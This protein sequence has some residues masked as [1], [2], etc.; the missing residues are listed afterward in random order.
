MQVE[1]AF[2]EIRLE[3]IQ[4]ICQLA[5]KGGTSQLKRLSP[6]ERKMLLLMV[7]AMGKGKESIETETHIDLETLKQRL[8]SPER[9]ESSTLRQKI[10]KGFQKLTGGTVSS[11][12]LSKEIAKVNP[13]RMSADQVRREQ[14]RFHEDIKSKTEEKYDKQRERLSPVI[15]MQKYY[16][17]L[18]ECRNKEQQDRE[19]KRIL[20][21]TSLP[22]KT[23]TN[24]LHLER[25][26]HYKQL[27]ANLEYIQPL[28]EKQRKQHLEMFLSQ[29]L[30]TYTQLLAEHTEWRQIIGQES[31]IIKELKSR[32]I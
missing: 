16:Q 24:P 17:L 5:Q 20:G 14:I 11:E 19:I 21:E 13:L 28:T 25:Y 29:M 9:H 10:E 31:G 1:E 15:Q 23:P 3:Q 18:L 30:E 6:E 32:Q 27:Y 2:M 26:R 12:R 8:S 4:A 22:K 7:K